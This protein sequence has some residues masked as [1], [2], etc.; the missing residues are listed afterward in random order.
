[1]KQLTKILSL[2]ICLALALSLCA[3]GGNETK[4]SNLMTDDESE[5]V[6]LTWMVRNSQPKGF[7]EV[8]AAANEYLGEKLNI[9]LNLQCIEPGDYESKVQLALAS[10]E[11]VDIIWTSDWANDYPGNSNKGAFLALDEYLELP[12]LQGLKNYYG[13]HL[14][15]AVRINNKIYGVP[16]EQMFHVQEGYRFHKGIADKYE[17]VE[18]RIR[19]LAWVDDET[20]GTMEELEEVFDIV[21]AG[22]SSDF[23]IATASFDTF[24]NKHTVIAGYELIDDKVYVMSDEEEVE[25][26]ANHRR[27]NEKGY[28]PADVATNDNLEAYQKAGKVF[29]RYNRYF[30]GVEERYHGGPHDFDAIIIPTSDMVLTR[31]GIQSTINAISLNCKNPVRALK[32]MYLMHTDEYIMNLLSYGLEG[33]D[34]TKDPENPKRF[35]KNGDGYYL[36]EFL[37]G[38]NF[39]CY[40]YPTYDDDTW[41]QIRHENETAKVDK[42]IGF[43]FDR[44]NIESEISQVSAVDGEYGKILGFGLDA[45]YE[46]LYYEMDKKRDLAGRQ[47]IIDEIQRQLDEW[48]ATQE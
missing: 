26:C 36:P 25:L 32:L 7:D 3:C 6:N 22:E 13:E 11:D 10:G 18:E 27:W 2:V 29:T 4:Q 14:W 37:I 31:E 21:R 12:E 17:G 40:L 41:D 47:I 8:I 42:Y 19:N 28:F 5:H 30:A 48:L 34:Y 39:L 23:S 46:S 35:T 44:S 20:H 38:S 16:V 45:D 33:R 9:T 15:D 24:K 1:M 43:D